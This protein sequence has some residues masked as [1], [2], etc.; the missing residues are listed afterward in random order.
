MEL[1]VMIFFLKE[2]RFT[3]LNICFSFLV[4]TSFSLINQI[5]EFYEGD[6]RKFYSSLK[7]KSNKIILLCLHKRMF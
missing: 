4:L 3:P 5:T 1:F 7:S 2:P 6:F